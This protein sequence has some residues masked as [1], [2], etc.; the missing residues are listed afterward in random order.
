MITGATNIGYNCSK[1]L[2][3]LPGLFSTV[4][5]CAVCLF[6]QFYLDFSWFVYM[7]ILVFDDVLHEFSHLLYSSQRVFFVIKFD[8]KFQHVR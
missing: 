7:S 4:S 3:P 5:M 2:L 1:Q 6:P 8:S